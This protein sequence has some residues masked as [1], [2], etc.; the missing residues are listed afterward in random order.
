MMVSGT[1]SVLKDVFSCPLGL[2]R[3]DAWAIG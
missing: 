1:V 2:H 3:G